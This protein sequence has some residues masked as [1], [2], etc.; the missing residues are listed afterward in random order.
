MFVPTQAYALVI[1]SGE[2]PE[3]RAR[4]GQVSGSVP[5]LSVRQT[6]S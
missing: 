4:A 1:A 2:D 6:W 5:P 3:E